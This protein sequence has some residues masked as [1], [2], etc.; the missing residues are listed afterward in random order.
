M[1]LLFKLVLVP[2]LIALV[3]MA[4]RRFGPRVGGWLNALPLV[5]G[6]VLFFLA[7][8][9]GDQ[10][11]ARAA[12][13]TLAGLAAVAA[14]AVIYSWVATRRPWWVCVL[15][16]WIAFAALTVALQAVPWTAVSA[17]A[18][19]LAAFGIAPFVLP[20]VPDAPPPAAAPTWDLP[21]RMASAVALVLVVTGLAAWL[22]P[23]LSGAITPFPIA[24]TILLAFTHGQQGAPAAVGFLRAFLPAMWSFALFCFVLT[25]GVVGLGRDLGFLA[26]LAVS[27]A[28]QGAVWL[29]LDARAS[30]GSAR[31]GP[32][33]ARRSA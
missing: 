5:A 31:P 9:Q 28:V 17:L 25:V 22:G 20:P 29:G 11:V 3:T 10:F 16:G 27:L 6:P 24:T 1:T 4:G 30:R 18:L 12:Q 14:F 19:A 2:G 23:R 26:A 7:L 8:E 33:P 13:S 21:L 32:R 15:V